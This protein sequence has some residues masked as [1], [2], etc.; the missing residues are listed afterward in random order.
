MQ[1]YQRTWRNFQKFLQDNDLSTD[2]PVSLNSVYQYIAFLQGEGFAASSIASAVSAVG[3][4][5]KLH[6]VADPTDH[7]IVKRL[8]QGCRKAGSVQ[9]TRLPIT[10]QILKRLVAASIAT[11]SGSYQR[12]L[13]QA[14]YVLAFRALLRIGEMTLGNNPANLLQLADVQWGEEGVQNNV[15]KF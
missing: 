14:M 2:L 6:S 15:S 9:D 8:V 1:A 3:C 7:Y 4:I 11:I 10:L 13:F 12:K 5:H